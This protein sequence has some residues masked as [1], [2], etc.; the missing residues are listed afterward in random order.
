[1][2]LTNIKIFLKIGVLFILISQMIYI[3]N[4]QQSVKKHQ[5]QT[6]LAQQKA[7]HYAEANQQLA[8]RNIQNIEMLEQF[9]QQNQALSQQILS[10]LDEQEQQQ[11]RLKEVLNEKQNKNWS[12]SVIPADVSRLLNTKNSNYRSQQSKTN[13]R[14]LPSN[15][16][17]PNATNKI[18]NK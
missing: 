4:L 14:N 9:Q 11:A 15:S 1:M 8:Q 6:E 16:N 10:K 7:D 18:Q 12:N 17:L 5:A 13:T 2:W 3:K